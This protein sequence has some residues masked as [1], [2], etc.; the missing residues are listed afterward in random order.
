MTPC[1]S[2][3]SVAS[4]A[5]PIVRAAWYRRIGTL[6]GLAMVARILAI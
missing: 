4:E 1:P 2:V 5:Y 6:A 3:E